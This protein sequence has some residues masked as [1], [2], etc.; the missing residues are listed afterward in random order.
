[1]ADFR[2]SHRMLGVGTSVQGDSS[3]FC[4][5]SAWNLALTSSRHRLPMLSFFLGILFF[6][7]LGL[8]C[9]LSLQR[10]R[11]WSVWHSALG[12]TLVCRTSF[13]SRWRTSTKSS[14]CQC[15]DRG[16]IQVVFRLSFCW[17]VVLVMASWCSA[18]NS[19]RRRPLSLQLPT[20]CLPRTPFQAS[21]SLSS[22]EVAKDEDLVVFSGV[23]QESAQ[24][25][26]EDVFVRRVCQKSGSVDTEE[27]E[28]LFALQW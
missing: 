23:V 5:R 13:R 24:I 19:S 10:T 3:S 12:I 16:C 6:L 26:I 18:Q 14:R 11:R 20:P 9:S 1:M 7:S 17:K 28:M 21:E 8:N 25:G 4:C 2:F 22:I 15:F 27:R